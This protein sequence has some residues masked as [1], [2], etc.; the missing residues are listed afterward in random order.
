MAR[1]NPSWGEERIAA[2]L[3]VKLG[4]RVP[5]RTVRRYL[6]RGHAGGGRR[7]SGQR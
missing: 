4:L 2:E 3:L 5:P 6:G 1:D 7:A